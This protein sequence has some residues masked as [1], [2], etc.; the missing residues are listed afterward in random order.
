MKKYGDMLKD[1]RDNRIDAAVETAARLYLEKGID[2]V[3]MTDIAEECGIG[4]ASLYRYF[5]TKQNFTVKAA[6]YIWNR[7]MALFEGVYDSEYY[8]SKC[9]RDQIEE[10]LKVFHVL[11]Q[12]HRDFLCFVSSFDAYIIREG[13]THQELAEYNAAV[14][15]TMKLMEEAAEKGIADGSV[16]SDVDIHLYYFTVTHSLM[17][18]C[19]K[20][21]AGS[22]LESDDMKTDD[23]EVL[24]AIKMYLNF[25]SA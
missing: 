22:L 24:M 7:Q 10:L 14:M 3:K 25:I 2:V 16:R 13:I 4:V 11:H 18:L 15:D 19:Q 5:G 17:S 1:V 6:V 20:L 8:R 21:A 23:D 12:A 9:G